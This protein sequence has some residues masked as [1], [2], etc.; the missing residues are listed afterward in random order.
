MNTQARK[1]Q[2]K[3]KLHSVVLGTIVTYR[4]MKQK[5]HSVVSGTII[6]Y[7]IMCK[8]SDAL[9]SINSPVD[10][11]DLVALALNGLGKEYKNFDTSIAVR[12]GNPPDFDELCSL[13]ITEELKLGLGTSSSSI[14][15][16][17]R[18]QAFYSRGARGRG[19][20]FTRGRGVGRGWQDRPPQQQNFQQSYGARGRN[21]YAPARGRAG[22]HGGHG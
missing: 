6:T 4:I 16:H 11:S 13:L 8:T 14:G 7:R 15:G 22:A 9:A 2:L 5:L 21:T 18:D 10:D 19:R 1:L 3:Q 20:T 17:S 12:G